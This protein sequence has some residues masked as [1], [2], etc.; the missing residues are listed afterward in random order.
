MNKT[1]GEKNN[2]YFL[3]IIEWLPLLIILQFLWLISSLPLLTIGS[4]SR[5][6]IHTIYL[7]RKKKEIRISLLFWEEFHYNLAT[8]GKQDIISSLYF[9]LLLIDSRIFA[10]L[11][12]SIR[13][14]FNVCL[15]VFTLLEC[16]LVCLSDDDTTKQS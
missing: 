16:S 3:M 2:D 15:L 5:A 8:Y 4:A 14:Y 1:F 9:L 6:V 7:Y 13:I 12:G 11:G 10:H